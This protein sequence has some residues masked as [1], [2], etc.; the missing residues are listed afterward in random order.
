MAKDVCGG[1]GERAARKGLAGAGNLHFLHM[2]TRLES[3]VNC[4]E[5]KRCLLFGEVPR[6]VVESPSME[7]F[8]KHGVVA[9]RGRGLVDSIG[10]R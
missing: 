9:L 6:E 10:G 8:K 5:L 4:L 3:I 1:R 7:V 2:E